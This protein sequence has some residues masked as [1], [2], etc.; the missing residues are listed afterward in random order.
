MRYA[1]RPGLAAYFLHRLTGIG[2]W[3]FLLIH[4]T[5]SI[6]LKMGPEHWNRMIALYRTPLFAWLELGLLGALLFHGA[7]GLRVIIVDFTA[8]RT[9]LLHKVL[10]GL[11]VVAVVSLLVPAAWLM[12]GDQL[13]VALAALGVGEG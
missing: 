13:R 4:V 10:L 6:F 8:T 9:D 1:P 12:V 7:N 3:L 11:V 2:I 5:E